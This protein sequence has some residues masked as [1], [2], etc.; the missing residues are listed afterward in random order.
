M[1]RRI[2]IGSLRYVARNMVETCDALFANF[3][4]LLT[5]QIFRAQ[6]VEIMQKPK[7]Y[8]LNLEERNGQ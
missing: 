3:P 6:V 2:G 1:S 4:G 5:K 8:I 7:Q